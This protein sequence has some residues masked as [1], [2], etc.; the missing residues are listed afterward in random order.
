MAAKLT[1][2]DGTVDERTI[3]QEFTRRG[4]RPQHW[5]NGP[6][7]VYARHAHSYHKLL[8]CLRGSIAFA[9]AGVETIELRAGDRLE[10]DAGTEHSAVVGPDGC[11]CVEAPIPRE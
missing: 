10:I 4:L 11:A 7:D 2:G 8:Y 3:D 9:I 6:H 5:S 1:R